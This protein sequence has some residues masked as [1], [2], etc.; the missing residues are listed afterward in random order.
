M[1]GDGDIP[2]PDLESVHQITY[3]LGLAII[4][5]RFPNADPPHGGII[6]S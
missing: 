2:A 4:F 6:G 1:T 3:I 5:R